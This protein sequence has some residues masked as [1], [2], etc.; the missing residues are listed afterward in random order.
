MSLINFAPIQ[1]G[2]TATDDL[3]NTRFAALVNLVNGGLDADNIKDNSISTSKIVDG[4]VTTVKIP[5]NAVTAAK[6]ETQQQWIA[7][8][9]ENGWVNYATVDT[10]WDVAGYMKD[11]LGFV[12]MKGLIRAGTVGARIF[13]LPA[14]YRPSKYLLFAV[15]SNST[16]GRI[17]VRNDGQV[18][19]Q[20][21]GN[22]YFNLDNII[23][24]AEQ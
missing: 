22:A 18:I 11:S 16:I 8:T 13:T 5:N 1:D 23:F 17:D 19:A 20:S 24:K 7:P 12:H 15:H 14:G 10:V 6:I 4:A 2:D 3:F 9:F 21:G